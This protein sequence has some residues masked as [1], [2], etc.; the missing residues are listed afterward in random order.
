MFCKSPHRQMEGEESMMLT[1]SV[2]ANFSSNVL[3]N[4][5]EEVGITRLNA[6]DSFD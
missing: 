1:S 6:L 5:V 4:G 2:F 3:Y